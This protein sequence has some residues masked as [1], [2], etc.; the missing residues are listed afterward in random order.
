MVVRFL[1]ESIPW[2]V[3]QK[4]YKHLKQVVSYAARINQK[5][6]P[7]IVY[8]PEENNVTQVKMGLNASKSLFGVLTRSYPNQPAQLQRL[9]RK[10]KFCL[11]QV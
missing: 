1:P 4:K 3:S 10:S 8:H 6:I 5:E 9:H 11:H 2:L 7:E